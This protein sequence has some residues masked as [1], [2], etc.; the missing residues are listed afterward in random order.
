M[1]TA[2]IRLHELV[3]Y[4]FLPPRHENYVSA[5]NLLIKNLPFAIETADKYFFDVVVS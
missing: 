2:W 4:S 3:D 5:R 1:V